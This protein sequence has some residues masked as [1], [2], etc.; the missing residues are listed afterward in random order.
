MLLPSYLTH[1][2]ISNSSRLS[3]TYKHIII[4]V[5]SLCLLLILI[6]LITLLYRCI[7][8]RN[9]PKQNHISIHNPV[10]DPEHQTQDPTL[11]KDVD[12]RY[13]YDKITD[14]YLEIV[15]E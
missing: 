4:V 10:Y 9:I 13:E 1:I 12:P 5:G 6:I 14:E 7:K 2:I 11:Y 15:N 8:S 3:K